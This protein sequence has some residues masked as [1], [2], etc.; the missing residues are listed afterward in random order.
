M[1]D[2]VYNRN[3]YDEDDEKDYDQNTSCEETGNSE[4]TSRPPSVV[5]TSK[6]TTTSGGRNYS[7]VYQASGVYDS[8]NTYS[9]S[10][11][12]QPPVSQSEKKKESAYQYN[13]LSIAN[14]VQTSKF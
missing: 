8:A 5:I 12:N 2:K 6:E 7:D 10:L 9:S 11:Q 14:I 1:S 3:F 13:P 4:Q